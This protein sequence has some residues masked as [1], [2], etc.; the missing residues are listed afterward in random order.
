MKHVLSMAVSFGALCIAT[1]AAYA[2]CG[3]EA[4]SVR[5][6]S[7]DFEALRIVASEAEECASDTVTVTKNQ[8]EEHKNLQV[9]ALTIDPAE[10]TIAMVA[11]NSLVPLLNDDL[12]Q[13]MDDLVEK[14]GQDLLPNQL[15]RID[16]KVMA[17]A[18]MANAQ[19]FFYRSD[20]LEEA[21]LEPPTSY[22]EI[23]EAAKVIQDQGLMEYPLIASN[24]AGW[25][26]AAEFVNMYL[27][28][29]GEFFAPGS[30]EIAINNEDGL[31]VLATMKEMTEY[32]D[33]DYMTYSANEMKADWEAGRVAMMT[34]WGS[35]AGATIDDEGS[36]PEITGA[37][38]LTAAPTVGGGDIPAVALWW[39]GFALA[40]NISD[41]DAE[42]S[43]QAMMHGIRPEVA[44][45]YPEAA[46]WLI[47]G[48]EPG[49]GAVGVVATANA[50]A[51][52]YP[53]SPYIGLL[54]TALG[55]E[56]AEFMQ[57]N[58]SAEDALADVEAAY[59]AAATEAGFLN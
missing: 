9:P 16:G 12:V 3:I 32:M 45:M 26:L 58:E 27:G 15:I 24:K 49:A 55:S 18:F 59:T 19:H 17:I 14:Y 8:T 30:A 28:T 57:G 31:Q 25:D 42:A 10:Y 7:N 38:V 20:I 50:G 6:L 33:P 53:M 1:G 2:D 34:E 37:T 43:F 54:H 36:T 51:R 39:D 46:T 52:P 5:I 29:G 23:I 21:G 40:K 41:E 47:K 4:G 48:Y 13:P 11:N 56:L 35:L 22:E 44:E